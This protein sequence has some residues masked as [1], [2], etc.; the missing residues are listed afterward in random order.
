METSYLA[1]LVLL[2]TGMSTVGVSAFI[3]LGYF[4]KIKAINNKVS[5]QQIIEIARRFDGELSAIALAE[6]TGISLSDAKL[7]INNLLM[8]GIVKQV[9]DWSDW[10]NV[11]SR[12]YL[13]DMQPHKLHLLKSSPA[14]LDN[15]KNP[16]DA[17]LINLAIQNRGVVSTSLVCIK[18]EVTVDV[19]QQRL[20]E[21]RKKEIFVTEVNENGTLLYRLIDGDLLAS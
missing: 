16:S 13:K 21:L 5:D 17:A 12:Y 1:I 20:E 8:N 2:L 10:Q 11:T 6:E 18:F 14:S 4:R 9:W 3:A 19:A 15:T 7:K